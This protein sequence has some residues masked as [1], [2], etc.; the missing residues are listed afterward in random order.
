[1]L[2]HFTAAAMACSLLFAGSAN[3]A[4]VKVMVSGAMAHALQQVSEDFAKKNGHT[5]DFF[6]STT[7]VVQDKV[8][9]GEK[10]DVVEV[11]AVG[12]DALEKEKLVVP[13]SRIDLARALIG[14]AVRDG[15]PVPDISTVDALKARLVAA[16]SVAWID[17]KVGGQAGAAIVSLLQKMGIT[18]DVMKKSVFAKTGGEAVQKMAA[19][20]AD[21]AISFIS[22]IK[23]IKG[24]KVVGPLPAAVQ[25]PSTYAG[26]IGINSAN[27]DLARALLKVMA[28]AESRPVMVEAGLEPI[29]H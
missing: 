24:A 2:K 6:A 8:R 21:I 23:P 9:A 14:V 15:A 11:T 12:M 5:L 25:N 27:P 20:E 19:G 3:A 4:Q 29:A 22:E 18:D 1:M 7:G 16:K 17:P 10:V 13:G 26:A 28:G